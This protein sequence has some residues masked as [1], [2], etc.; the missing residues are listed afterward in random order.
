M[1]RKLATLR[2]VTEILPI[3]GADLIEL[4]KIDGWQC[5]AKKGEFKVGSIGVYFEID[6][7]LDH[8]RPEFA[9]LAPRAIKWDGKEGARIKSMKL[10]GQL[11]QGLL[12]PISAWPRTETAPGLED[13]LVDSMGI[14]GYTLDE[15]NERTDFDTLWNVQKWEKILAANLAGTAKGN[16]PSFIF[17]T[18]QER[19]QNISNLFE[20]YGDELFQVTKKLDGSSLTAYVVGLSSKHYV[21]SEVEGEA[22]GLRPNIGVC[23][24]NL[25]LVDTEGNA[26]WQQARRDDLHTKLGKMMR[27]T[28]RPALAIQG[29]MIGQGIQDNH[30][31]CTGENEFYVY[32]IFDIDAG[33]YLDPFAASLLCEDV[34][35]NHV[36][37]VHDSIRLSD[38]AVDREDLLKKAVGPSMRTKVGEGDVFK[39]LKGN[40]VFK[41]AS[42][43][44]FSFKVISNEYLLKTGN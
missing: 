35:L 8:T 29:E 25:D 33:A 27:I 30:E 17:K 12:L 18:D 1:T 41:N 4:V 10:K 7:F 16:F 39:L 38:Y 44:D 22:V 19:V 42:D 14:D 28:A 9:F 15:V 3:E 11:S 21:P 40:R 32:D 34:G 36:P 24:R 43:G 6:S 37:I 23:S 2:E 31:K 5:V 26:F 13:Y 20:R